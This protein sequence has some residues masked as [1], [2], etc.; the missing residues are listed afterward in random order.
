[1]IKRIFTLTLLLGLLSAIPAWAESALK[2]SDSKIDFGSMT[3]GPVATK[4]VTL[5]NISNEVLTI[6]NVSTS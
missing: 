1:M 2:I 3:E 6:Q 4:S 5:K